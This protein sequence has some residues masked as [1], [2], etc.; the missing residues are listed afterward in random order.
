MHPRLIAYIC[1]VAVGFGL[2]WLA[3]AFSIALARRFGIVA[4]PNNRTSHTGEIPRIGG[5]GIAIPVLLAFVAALVLL[6]PPE[7]EPLPEWLA[8]LFGTTML[9]DTAR[10]FLLA[11]VIGGGAAFL[12]GFI[13]DARSLPAKAK[14]LGQVVIA[15][16]PAVFGIVVTPGHFGVQPDAAGTSS[17]LV[18][19]GGAALGTLWVLFWMNAYNFMDGMN[20]HAARFAELV[21]LALSVLAAGR[22][23]FLV[24]GVAVG[25]CFGFLPFNAPTPRTFMGD[26]GSLAMGYF[27][28]IL[29][30]QLGRGHSAGGGEVLHAAAALALTLPFAWDVIYTLFVRL[31]RGENLFVA[32]RSHL[33]QRLLKLG[34]AHE[35]VLRIAT[36]TFQVCALFAVVSMLFA[37]QAAW[38]PWAALAGAV[39]VQAL[40]TKYVWGR[41]RS[42]GVTSGGGAGDPGQ[43]ID[44]PPGSFPPY[45]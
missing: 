1:S 4:R 36:R 5:I 15:A 43:P 45:R 12:L 32:H 39:G 8:I 14:L 3:T 7:L 23:E 26:C 29:T 33:Y 34:D 13:D 35:Q 28:G 25:A 24:L 22:P 41:E 10:P 2:A 38:A 42:A 17:A 19:Y 6:P 11:S 18:A 21:L 40:Y 20:G 30:M 44:G 16:I 31:R 37:A 27:I 9:I